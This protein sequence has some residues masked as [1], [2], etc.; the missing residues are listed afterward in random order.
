MII[1]HNEERSIQ[2]KY[3]I[4]AL[5]V[6]Y[7]NSKEFI[8]YFSL[9]ITIELL[10]DW[11]IK[12]KFFK[13]NNYEH[14]IQINKTIIA[15]F[16]SLVYTMDVEKEF[17]LS[18]KSRFKSVCVYMCCCRSVSSRLANWTDFDWKNFTKPVLKA[19]IY[20]L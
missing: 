4:H 5:C 15:Y 14:L 16:S 20:A 6:A 2:T 1:E 11:Q 9:T 19:R 17:W 13:K 10:P 7:T 12:L 8:L 18:S 3:I